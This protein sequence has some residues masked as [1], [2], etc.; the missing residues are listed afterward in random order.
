MLIPCPFPL[1][2]TH[3]NH[4]SPLKKPPQIIK[5]LPMQAVREGVQRRF[6]I[7][8]DLHVHYVPTSPC[9]GLSTK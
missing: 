6:I 7:H 1:P 5:L 4:L 8:V 9:K 3:P 2:T